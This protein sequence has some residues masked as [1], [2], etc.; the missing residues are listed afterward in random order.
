M[1][2]RLF[3][4]GHGTLGQDGF[5]GLLTEGGIERIVDV[6]RFPGSRKHPHMKCEALERWLP[7]AGVEYRWEQRLGGRRSTGGDSPDTWWQVPAFRAYAGY[8]RTPEFLAGVDA[9]TE[10]TAVRRTAVMC[11]ETVWWRC[12]RRMISDFVTLVRG[13]T[14]SHLGHDGRLTEHPPADGA[15]VEDG[16]L[17]YDRAP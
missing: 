11:S 12:H 10:D 7:A 15:R 2:G 16:L 6:R 14:V 8:M 5:S 4:V 17:F 1:P 9:L 13:W 3:T